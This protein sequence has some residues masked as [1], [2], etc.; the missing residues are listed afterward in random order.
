MSLA[1]RKPARQSPTVPGVR[2][3]ALAVQVRLFDC[4]A[5][6]SRI[7]LCEIKNLAIILSV[8]L[9]S[10]FLHTNAK[11]WSGAGHQV[12]AAEAYRQLSA[13]LKKK[14]TEILKSHPAYEK[15]EKAISAAYSHFLA[16]AE[17]VNLT[18]GHPQ[19]LPFS[20]RSRPPY[21]SDCLYDC[22][23]QRTLLWWHKHIWCLCH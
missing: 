2:P 5:G 16:V 14:V 18:G 19:L 3:G 1:Q 22:P 15:W 20:G 17:L 23:F 21:E 10:L 8:S 4:H 7:R 13:D 9:S 12:L 6:S 11:A